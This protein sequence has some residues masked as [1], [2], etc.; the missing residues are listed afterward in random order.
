MS[1]QLP[2]QRHR[3]PRLS[4]GTLASVEID[5]HGQGRARHRHQSVG[6]VRRVQ[7]N[8]SYAFVHGV[9]QEGADACGESQFQK[10]APLGLPRAP[11]VPDLRRRTLARL[12]PCAQTVSCRAHAGPGGRGGGEAQLGAVSVVV[13]AEIGAWGTQKQRQNTTRDELQELKQTWING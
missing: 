9:Q 13:T 5:A 12:L 10:G 8:A 7:R 6:F 2:R 3:A 11:G 1:L 4:A